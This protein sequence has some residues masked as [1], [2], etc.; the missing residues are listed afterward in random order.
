MSD[1]VMGWLDVI[2]V[3]G[4][5]ILLVAGGLCIRGC[6]GRGYSCGAEDDQP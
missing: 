4:F 2:E 6:W 3:I 1:V 5:L